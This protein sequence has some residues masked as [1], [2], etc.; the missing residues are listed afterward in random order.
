MLLR[1][2]AIAM[3]VYYL[4]VIRVVFYFAFECAGVPLLLAI[5]LFGRQPQKV[6][7]F[8]CMIYYVAILALPILIVLLNLNQRVSTLMAACSF[9]IV[10]PFLA[11]TP[12][13]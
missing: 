7:A 2:S 10:L 6:E 9:Y 1:V 12:A 3:C 4:T 13:Y 5:L 8:K 11:K